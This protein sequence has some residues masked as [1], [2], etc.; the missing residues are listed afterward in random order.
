[1]SEV[2]NDE[3]RLEVFITFFKLVNFFSINK[4]YAIG[5]RIGN[6]YLELY[7]YETLN[8]LLFFRIYMQ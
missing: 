8:Q 1:M 2:L 5:L 3:M 7:H 4:I 6:A